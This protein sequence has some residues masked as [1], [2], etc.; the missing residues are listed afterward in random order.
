MLNIVEDV[1]VG[2]GGSGTTTNMT[3][4]EDEIIRKTSDDVEG[5]DLGESLHRIRL[6][7]SEANGETLRECGT[8]DVDGD[9]I[10]RNVHAPIEKNDTF[11]VI[12][13]VSINVKN[14][15]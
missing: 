4:L 10:T 1:A 8:L 5:Q 13:E 12:Y 7:T 11:E 14:K 3:S 9:L 15:E 2:S 6:T